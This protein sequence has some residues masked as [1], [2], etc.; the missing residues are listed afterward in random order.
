MRKTKTTYAAA[1]AALLS[2]FVIAAPTTLTARDAGL[3]SHRNVQIDHVGKYLQVTADI[4]LDSVQVDRDAQMFI[5][6]IATLSDSLEIPMQTMLVNGRNMQYVWE[7]GSLPKS[8][9]EG[10]DITKVVRRDNGKKQTE[11]IIGRI[12]WED[13]MYREGV[14]V[15]FC[16]DQCG[17]G[18]LDWKQCGEPIVLPPVIE[19]FNDTIVTQETDAMEQP[20]DLHGGKARVQFEVDSITLHPAV[21]RCRSGQVIDNRQQLQTIIDSINYALTDPHVE[22]AEIEVVGYASPESPYE[23]NSYLATGRSRALAEWIA[24]R[25]NLPQE[26]TK[27]DAVP[28]NWVEFRAM[29]DGDSIPMT[30]EQKRDLLELIDRPVFGP[31]DYD[32]KER[33]LKTDKRFAKLYKDVILPEWFPKLRATKFII[34]TKLKE[35]TPEELKEQALKTPKMLTINQLIRAAQQYA[36]GSPQYDEIID[37]T[38]QTYPDSPEANT[39]AAV[40]RIHHGQ[41]AEAEEYLKKA[42][43]SPEAENA[44]GIVAVWRGKIDE[45]REHFRRASSLA[46]ARSN[47]A[48]LGD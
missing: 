18:A 4:V 21:Y 17:C 6:P 16:S 26:K 2:A 32:A 22:I 39:N 43:G 1:A 27:Y 41:Y 14:S 30:P 37:L 34:K 35:L 10:Y 24:E 12:P 11:E 31:A 48:K 9:T 47:A 15:R 45:A 7:R 28:E 38:V 3:F 13:W 42:G 40:S 23:H 20:V 8:L 36:T 25:Y 33:I 5:T 46:A 44:R 19:T 29:V